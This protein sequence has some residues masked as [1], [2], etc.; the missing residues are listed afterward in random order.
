MPKSIRTREATDDLEGIVRYIARDNLSAA[1]AW[2]DQMESLFRLLATQPEMGERVA[3]RRY[4]DCRRYVA[5]SY[6]V[7]Y[8][9]IREGVE[10]LHVVHGAREERRI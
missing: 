3:T 5:G 6:V 10:I 7:Y 4:G 9:A 1:L 2:L 8:W